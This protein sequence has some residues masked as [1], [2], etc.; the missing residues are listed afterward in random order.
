MFYGFVITEA[1]NR[2]LAKMVAG[3]TLEL[4]GVVMEKGT[5]ES[6]EAARKLTAPIDPGPAGTST[7]PTVKDSTATM[8][9]EYRSDLNGGLAVG[10]WIGGFAIYAKDP[11]TR[12]NVMVYYGSLGDA[13]QY[14]SAYT[15]GMA[16]DVRRYQVSITVTAGVEVS[17]GYPAEAWMTAQDVADYCT[18]AVMPQIYGQIA[19]EILTGRV[20]TPLADR[21]GEEIVTRD[22]AGISV[23][24]KETESGQESGG[25]VNGNEAAL[26]FQ[27]IDDMRAD[28]TRRLQALTNA[29]MSGRLDTPLADR[30]GAAITTRDSAEISAVKI[31]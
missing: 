30:Q 14:V 7:V 24:R 8:T 29:I 5:A 12:E 15:Q 10:F 17:L 4:S 23:Y 6:A 11:D 28:Y 20:Y 3:Q 13:K 26:L 18:A 21:T 1:G 9:V 16:P 2:L 27:L 22:G 19:G 31:L 25:S